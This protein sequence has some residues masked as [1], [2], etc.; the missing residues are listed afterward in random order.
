MFVVPMSFR[1]HLLVVLFL[2]LSTSANARL[3]GFGG[4]SWKEEVL[5]HDGSKIIVKRSQSYGG[6]HEI[7]QSSPIKEHTISFTLPDSSKSI[8]WTSEYSGDIGRTNFKLI[9]VH[10]LKGTPYLL[11]SPNG[12]YSYGKWGR[13]NPPY[14]YFKYDGKEWQR[15]HRKEFPVEF[16]TINVALSLGGQDFKTMLKLDLVPAE[17]IRELNSDVRIPEYKTIVREPMDRQGVCPPP[18]GSDGR[19]I[20]FVQ[21]D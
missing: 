7:G 5:L 11:A 18:T 12:C 21:Y 14:V 19:L 8:T 15:I 20:P 1:P 9:A 17:K 6:R 13:P 10:V 2:T 16:K 4:D 3:L